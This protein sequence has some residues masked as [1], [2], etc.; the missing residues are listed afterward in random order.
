MTDRL[1]VQIATEWGTGIF[2]SEI[3]LSHACVNRNYSQSPIRK[4]FW[5]IG[6]TERHSRP[7][8]AVSFDHWREKRSWTNSFGSPMRLTAAFEM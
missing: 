5:G 2:G 1:E 3:N 8:A 6:H 7:G 4:I